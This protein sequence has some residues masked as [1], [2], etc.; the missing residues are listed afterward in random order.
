MNAPSTEFAQPLQESWIDRIFMRLHGRFGNQFFDKYR[1]G[2]SIRT[3]RQDANGDEVL[4]DAGVMNA[5]TVW[6]EELAGFSVDE[7]KAGLSAKY[8]FPPSCDEFAKA[9]RPVAAH[10]D[11]TLFLQACNCALRRKNRESEN[12]PSNRLFWAYQRIGPEILGERTRD[13]KKRFAVAYLEAEW[14]AN[15]PIPQPV[16]ALALPPVGKTTVSREEA[17]KRSALLRQAANVG[18]VTQFTSWAYAIAKDP[19]AVPTTSVEKAIKAFIAWNVA[20]PQTLID[21]AK[22]QGLEKFLPELAA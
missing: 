14:D 12:W 11:E 7:L 20:I 3:G 8:A 6:A 16:E 18:Q 1:T 2:Q 22:A 4:E 5:K 9:C 17:A 19:K 15:K 21:F 13:L 10:D